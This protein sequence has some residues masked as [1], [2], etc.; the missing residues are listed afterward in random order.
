MTLQRSQGDG[1]GERGIVEHRHRG[2]GAVHLPQ[3]FRLPLAGLADAH[4]L[5]HELTFLA[6]ERLVDV[7]RQDRV[8]D[9]MGRRVE[10]EETCRHLMP[11]W[12][13]AMPRAQTA[14]AIGRMLP[15]ALR[16]VILALAR[17]R[18]GFLNPAP[19]KNRKS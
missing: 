11:L 9:R 3:P 1:V 4:V 6:R 10:R 19:P 13:A 2:T 5:L 18:Y 14:V 16:S 7:P 12:G 15:L 8:D 17:R